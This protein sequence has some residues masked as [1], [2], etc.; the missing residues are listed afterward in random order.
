MQVN[1]GFSMESIDGPEEIEEECASEL[2][3]IHTR[4]SV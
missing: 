3:G 1:Y 4:F 2:S